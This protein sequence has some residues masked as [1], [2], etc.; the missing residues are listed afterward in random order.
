MLRLQL[1][2]LQADPSF[3]RWRDQV[4]AIAALPEEKSSIPMVRQQLPLILEIQAD[5]WSA[6]QGDLPPNRYV[7]A[8]TKQT[9]ALVM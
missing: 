5:E 1:A 3:E 4:R 2:L 8:L 7:Y 9:R 6:R